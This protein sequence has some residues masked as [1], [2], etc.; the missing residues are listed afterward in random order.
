[1]Y[2]VRFHL[3]AGPN[4]RKW[5]TTDLSTREVAYHDPEAVS[6]RLTGCRL[7]NRK[8]TASK[9]HGG[10]NKTVCAWIDCESVEVLPAAAPSGGSEVSYN[11]RVAPNW[12]DT[13]GNDVDG[14]GY[15]GIV[16]SGRAAF[17]LAG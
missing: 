13:Q 14:A 16:T 7:R 1:M 6:L 10:A 11:P 4:F 12:R 9:I 3:G 17:A 15:D 8:A 5:Q 2:R